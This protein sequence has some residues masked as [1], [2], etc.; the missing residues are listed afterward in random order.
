MYIG[1]IFRY[2][3]PYSPDPEIKD[4]LV[5]FFHETYTPNCKLPLLESG[6]NPI[7]SIRTSE[8]E[9]RAAILISSSPNKIG[10]HETPWQDFF[11]VDNGHIRYFGDN[12]RPEVRPEE[13][14]GN[15]ILLEQ[16]EIHNSPD[17]KIRK[18][19]VPILFFE[20]VKVDGRVKGN[21]QFKGFGVMERAE[22]VVQ[23]DSRLG[24]T[25]SNYVFDFTVLS[26]VEENEKFNWDWISKRRD[27]SLTLE[28]SLVYAPESWKIWIRSGS[29]VRE[30]LRRRVS[31]LMTLKPDEQ[32]PLVGTRERIVL[33]QIYAYYQKRSRFEALAAKVAGAILGKSTGQYVEGWVTPSSGDGGADFVGRLDVGSDFNRVKLIVLGQAKCEKFDSPTNGK[34]IARTVARLKRGWIGVYVTTSFFSQP[35]QREVIEDGYPLLLVNGLRLAQEVM[36]MAHERGFLDIKEFLKSLD[37]EYDSMVQARRPEEVL[38]L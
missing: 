35:V 6:I 10:T 28:E 37:F 7:G 4:G 16:F 19:S 17:P 26:I 24:R 27:S 9:R 15:R 1:Q 14:Q 31:K 34:D 36:K 12:K 11:D 20:R 21:V 13:S 30:R 29:G 3:R 5:N 8:G 25:F 33:D 2:S 18:N 23:Y 38:Y 22:K 32:R